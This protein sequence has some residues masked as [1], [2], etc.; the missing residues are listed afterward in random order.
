MLSFG[1]YKI[2]IAP[3]SMLAVFLVASTF[4]V[5][6]AFHQYKP[7]WSMPLSYLIMINECAALLVTLVYGIILHFS[8]FLYNRNKNSKE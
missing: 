2:G 5:F 1:K 4:A 3:L 8:I 7:Q 6:A